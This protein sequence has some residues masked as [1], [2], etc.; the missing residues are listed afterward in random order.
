MIKK[1][2]NKQQQVAAIPKNSDTLYYPAG[3]A[4]KTLTNL[5]WE[6]SQ[7]LNNLQKKQNLGEATD[8]KNVKRRLTAYV[9]NL[10]PHNITLSSPCAT[11]S[12]PHANQN[13]PS[14]ADRN[15]PQ[16]NE[17]WMT[18]KGKI[19]DDKKHHRHHHKYNDKRV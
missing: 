18:T 2:E 9:H 17:I 14:L 5:F 16:R 10:T 3:R 15:R 6:L 7:Q 11:I 19:E 13:K 8:N 4:D 12:Q 1:E